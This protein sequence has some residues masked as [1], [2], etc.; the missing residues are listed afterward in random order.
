MMATLLTG[1]IRFNRKLELSELA[2]GGSGA[3]TSGSD[4]GW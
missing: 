3:V 1:I 4:A 2:F